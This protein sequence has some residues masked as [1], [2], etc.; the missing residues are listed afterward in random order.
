MVCVLGSIF[1]SVLIKTFIFMHLFV[2]HIGIISTRSSFYKIL[3]L[4]LL[5]LQNHGNPDAAHFPFLL[6][7]SVLHLTL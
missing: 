7:S 6:V 5:C 2:L 3:C 4:A 1:F